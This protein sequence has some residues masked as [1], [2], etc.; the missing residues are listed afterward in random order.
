VTNADHRV[1]LLANIAVLGAAVLA[2]PTSFGGVQASLDT[3]RRVSPKIGPRAVSERSHEGASDPA[4][5][6]D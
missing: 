4:S 5:D 3:S 6:V 2:A 1:S